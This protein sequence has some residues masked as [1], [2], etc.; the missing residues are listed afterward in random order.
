MDPRFVT[1]SLHAAIDYPVA[2]LLIGA[3]FLLGLGESEPIAK[4]LSVGVGV[5]ALVLTVLTNHRTGIIRVLPYKLHVAVDG[6][7]GVLFLFAPFI[8][9]FQDLD[10]WYYWLNSA[11]V[12]TVVSLSAPERSPEPTPA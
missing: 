7:V 4:W 3:P 1:K 12:L 9:G 5:A 2:A 6:A 10:A 8:F 11:A